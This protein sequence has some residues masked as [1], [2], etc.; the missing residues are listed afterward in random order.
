MARDE[1]GH[2]PPARRQLSAR[3]IGSLVGGFATVLLTASTVGG[4]VAPAQAV[5]QQIRP[6]TGWSV[7]AAD[8]GLSAEAGLSTDSPSPVDT[9]SPSDSV[10]TTDPGGPP[11]STEPP[12]PVETTTAPPPVVETTTAAPPVV[13]TTTG[14]P[15]PPPFS[16]PPASQ[17]PGQPGPQ[18]PGVPR[19]GVY[20]T[21]GDIAL[22][23]DY[24][25]RA[26]TVADLRVTLANTGEVTELVRLSYTM[27]A[28]LTDAGTGGCAAGSNGTSQ[29]AAW[30]VAPGGRFSTHV[31]VRVDGN[32]WKSMPLSGSVRATATVK[33]RPGVP[34]VTDNQGFAVLFPPGP[35]VPGVSLSAG[36]VNFDVTGQPTSLEVRLGNTGRTD[37]AGT[38]E[39][40]LPPGV[41]VPTAPAGCTA[42]GADRTRCDLGT[43]GAG[44]TGTARL[45]VSATTEAQRNAPLAGAVIGTLAPRAGKA[46]RIQ[47]SFRINAVAAQSTPAPGFGATPVGSQGALPPF[48]QVGERD[49]LTS[50]QKTAIALIGASVL[51]VVL[52]LTL[53]TTSL[54]R[55][56]VGE[57]PVGSAA[58]PAE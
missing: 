56:M 15:L 37:A 41:T 51:L 46:K 8:P 34:A 24:W 3:S 29:C 31:K 38:V 2:R 28:G 18:Q 30:T 12:P 43:I 52:A 45:P 9:P 27:P 47:M 26:A 23:Q 40:V 50:V 5:A 19:H 17:P 42:V 10:P 11:P 6:A 33:G 49:G 55:R 57:P 4:L 39:V 58:A 44:R 13:D 54:R 53:A 7:L 25:G 20:I 14:A 1:F 22:G 48:K 16:P 32:A 21:T 35:P 36:E